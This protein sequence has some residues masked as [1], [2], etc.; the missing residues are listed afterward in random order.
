MIGAS[1]QFLQTWDYGAQCSPQ[2]KRKE[3]YCH[4]AMILEI[5][6]S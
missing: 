1:Q 4:R 2:H 3:G 5:L 6:Y